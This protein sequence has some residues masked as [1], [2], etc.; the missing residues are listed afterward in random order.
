MND[1]QIKVL[2]ISRKWPPAVGGMETYSWEI[3]QELAIKWKL[4]GKLER[5][6]FVVQITI[7]EFRQLLQ[8]LTG[9]PC[10][11]RRL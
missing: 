3:S 10:I 5:C 6:G 11:I 1:R 7:V 8:V 4:E 9:C 2:L